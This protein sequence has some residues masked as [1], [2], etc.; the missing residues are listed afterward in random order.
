MKSAD[1]HVHTLFSDGSLS[2]EALVTEAARAGLDCISVVDHDTV[3]GVAASCRA[4]E[5]AGVEVLPGIEL[6]AEHEGCE[7]HILGYLFDPG[8]PA[9]RRQLVV[10]KELRRERVLKMVERLRERM[11][12]SVSADRVFALAGNGTVGRLHLAWALQE[13]GVV[14]S[15][16]EAFQK[17][18]GDRSPGY[19]CGF[20]FSPAEAVALIREAGGIPVLAHP[21]V[22]G[23]DEL[24]ISFIESGIRGIEVHYPEHSQGAVNHFLALA[25]EHDLLVTGGSDYHG[26]AK[27][28]V[29]LGA[30]RLP[31]ECVERLKE[32]A[33]EGQ[34]K[35]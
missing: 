12:V 7:V 24:I 13:E 18:I 35:G 17:Y 9:L 15:L 23:S 34:T 27:P 30:V 5:R 2:P 28:D 21:F 20:R 8:H 3:D 16:Q 14:S 19:V 6:T 33:A 10:L 11:A 1:L 22:I 26:K 29:K 31:Y 25:Q 4:G 32:A